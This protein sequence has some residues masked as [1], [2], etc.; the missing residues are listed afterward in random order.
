MQNEK[1]SDEITEI[2]RID[3]ELRKKATGDP[4][5]IEIGKRLGEIDRFNTQRCKEIISEFGWPTFELI[6]KEA[7]TSF[8][9]LVQHADHDIEF[10]EKCLELLKSAV[11]ENQAFIKDL[12]YLED[13]VLTGRGKE[14]KYGTQFILEG[15]K[16][17][18][19]KI[20]DPEN[21][22]KRR[23]EM[24]LEPFAKNQE[25]INERNKTY[26]EKMR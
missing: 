5:N 1:L 26:I 14:Q 8:W 7:A 18:P 4:K 13:R 9:L 23:A 25:K 20:T 6:G 22:E 16:F 19:K 3:Q 21:L 12:A 11:N 17:V 24:G 15:E 2:A 10:Q